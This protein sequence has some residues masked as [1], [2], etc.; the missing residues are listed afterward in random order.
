MSADEGGEG[1]EGSQAQGRVGGRSG[2]GDEANQGGEDSQPVE[3]F[4]CG[5]HI[6]SMLC[7]LLRGE[8]ATLLCALVMSF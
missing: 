8:V 3:S 5:E 6:S 7:G 2:V 4:L 1:R